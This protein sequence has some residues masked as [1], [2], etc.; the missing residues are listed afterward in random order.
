VDFDAAWIVGRL[1]PRMY[2][3]GGCANRSMERWF[4]GVYGAAHCNQWA[5]CGIG[6][7]ECVKWS[8]CHLG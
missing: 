5:I 1:G 8:S 4:W 3:V 7:Q 2:S 6:V